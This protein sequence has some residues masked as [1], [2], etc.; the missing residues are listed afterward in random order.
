MGATMVRER[1]EHIL[2]GCADARDVG[3]IHVD[4]VRETRREYFERGIDARFHAIRVPG[5]FVTD[6]VI[7]D[8]R[9]IVH[10]AERE[11]VHPSL[12]LSVYVHIQAHGVVENEPNGGF[13]RACEL[14]IAD[15]PALN[16]GMMNATKVAVELENL[17][18]ER[19]PVVTLRRGGRMRICCESDVRTLLS[20]VYGH[21]G[22]LAGDWVRSID[23][24]RTHA[25]G[26]RSRLERALQ[27]DPELW[28]VQIHV[29]AGLQDYL[30]HRHL[31]TDRDEVPAPFWDH[32]HARIHQ[33]AERQHVDVERQASKQAP[34]AGLIAMA[35]LEDSPR[36]LAASWYA[37][38]RDVTGVTHAGT[39]FTLSGCS[40]DAPHVPFGPYAIAGLFYLLNHLN[41]KD[42]MVMGRTPVQTDRMLAK[43][44][45]DPLMSFVLEAGGGNLIPIA[46]EDLDDE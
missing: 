28:R 42:V 3:Q 1:Q 19:C 33:E 16:C 5:A 22:Y 38:Q 27:S 6:D 4:A 24:L 39:V 20:D 45:H 14:K 31:R 10:L 29:T 36:R 32:V 17:L 37:R 18:I 8:V 13:V 34:L 12:P 41:A 40:Y 21:D 2:I 44:A 9:R 7:S 35:R 23:D 11:D 46:T 26:Q 43:I 15:D 30:H 25:R